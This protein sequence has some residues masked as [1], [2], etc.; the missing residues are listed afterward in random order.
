MANHANSRQVRLVLDALEPREVPNAAIRS[1]ET[2]ARVNTGSLP[3]S[4]S[5]W[6]NSTHHGFAVDAQAGY[7][8]AEG[9]R[10]TGGSAQ[11]SRV[12]RTDIYEADVSVTSDILADSLIPVTLFLRGRNLDTDAPGYY[13]V[14]V[15]R[16]LQ[17]A[18]VRVVDGQN[19]ILFHVDTQEWMTSEWLRVTLSAQGNLLRVQVQRLDNGLFLATDGTWQ[20]T[21]TCVIEGTDQTFLQAGSVGLARPAS[22]SGSVQFDNFVV[23]SVRNDAD[24]IPIREDNFDSDGYPTG[25]KHWNNGQTS[26]FQLTADQVL[27]GPRALQVTGSSRGAA[28]AWVDLALPSDVQVSAAIQVNSLIH[29]EIFLRGSQLDSDTPTYYA[30]RLQRGLVVELVRVVQGETTRLAS[31]LT[32]GYQSNEWIRLSL[33]VNGDLLRVQVYRVATGEYLNPSGDWG[34]VPTWAIEVRDAA[35]TDAGFAGVGRS[36]SYAGTLTFDEFVITTA[37]G[38]TSASPVTRFAFDGNPSGSL[39]PGWGQW[40]NTGVHGFQ[41]SSLTPYVRPNSLASVGNSSV[42]ARAWMQAPYDADVQIS[43]AVY[44]NGLVPA[45]LFLRGQNVDSATPTYYAVSV[46]RGVE[47]QLRRVVDGQSEVLATRNSRGWQSNQRIEVSFQAEGSV[48]RVRVQRTDTG[49]FL[50]SDG[51]WQS[52]VTDAIHLTDTT[53]TTGGFVGVGREARSKGRLLFHNITLTDLTNRDPSAPDAGENPTPPSSPDEELNPLPPTE[54][55]GVPPTQDN[56]ATPPSDDDSEIVSPPEEDTD[57]TT[58]PAENDDDTWAPWPTDPLLNP[59][60]PTLPRHYSHIRIAQLAYSANPMGAFEERLLRESVDLVIPNARFLERIAQIAPQTPQLIYSNASNIYLELLTDWLEYADRHGVPRESAF[61]HVTKPTPFSGD[62]ASSRPVRWFWSIQRGSEENWTDFTRTAR[63]SPDTFLLGNAGQSVAVG[64]PERYR[65]IHVSLSRA[66][67]A[68]WNG[69]LEYVSEVD[70]M[71]NPTQ[72]SRLALLQDGTNGFSRNGTIVFDPPRDWKTARIGTNERLFYVRIRTE[73]NGRPPEIVHLFGR[74]YVN[75]NGKSSGVIPAFDYLADRDGDGYL[76]DTEYR[77]RRTGFDARFEYES[78]LFYPAYGQMRFATNPSN[79]DYR[80]WAADF[81]RRLLD[82]HPQAHGLFM[83]NSIA[84]LAVG[85]DSVRESLSNYSEDYGRM[86]GEIDL[87]IGNRWILANTAGARESADAIYR[88]GVSYLE[89]FGIRPL[90]HNF[91]QYEALAEAIR[92]RAELSGGRSI[93][94]LDSHPMGGDPTDPRTQM[95]TLAYYYTI[96]DPDSTFLMFFGGA[97]P[98]SSWTR[99]WTEAVR[100]DIGQPLGDRRVFAEGADPS[101]TRLTYR[102]FA[103]DFENALVLYKPLSYTRNQ[104]GTIRDNT[105]TTHQLDGTYRILRADGTLSGPVRQV[106]IR[107]GEGFVLVRG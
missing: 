9:L 50:H 28:R 63:R 47:L 55:D 98:S 8:G 43:A 75:A 38:S 77:H 12:W 73:G 81:S 97:E 3:S 22:V 67:A 42:E 61:Y 13:G 44:L 99:H 24:L 92:R 96:A 53:I 101:N 83:D 90:A 70:A 41:V 21:P 14:T 5:Q 64:Y 78:R 26:D 23:S 30:V 74:D 57:E 36:S 58:S 11:A 19:T 79:A 80:R 33:T 35:I 29:A 60:A 76:N 48:L 18:L 51:T 16:G 103:R 49:E 87:A 95:A 62:S 84:R 37:P 66:G 107:N 40:S 100:Y 56:G 106:T 27:H 10:S 68:S 93:S 91:Q 105:A 46:T 72:W 54:E 85:Q 4:W 71:G 94:V 82:S 89:E 69:I 17:I 31:T 6:S 88:H 20:A 25:W 45:Y 34:I 7:L 1:A 104:T 39:P 102:V 86:L 2:F 32:Q 52:Q 15:Q 59:G 65:E